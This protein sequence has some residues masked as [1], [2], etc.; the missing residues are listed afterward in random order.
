[1]REE[2]QMQE[3]ITM[4]LL[5]L[6]FLLLLLLLLWGSLSLRKLLKVKAIPFYV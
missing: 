5:L 2:L 6:L 1:M 4:L 3:V